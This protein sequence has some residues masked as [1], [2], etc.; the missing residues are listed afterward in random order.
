MNS[1]SVFPIS[2]FLLNATL[3]FGQ[4]RYDESRLQWRLDSDQMTYVI[5]VNQ[6]KMV[7][8]LYWGPRLSSG[9]EIPKAKMGAESSSFDP[10]MSTTQLEYPAW[11]AGLS[12]EPALKV[13]SSNGDR[14]LVLEYSSAN[15]NG[16]LLE[17]RLRD[18]VQPIAVHLFYRVFED[19]GIIARW[20]KIEN[21][22][23]K[24]IVVEQVASATWNL[25]SGSGY[26]WS[27]LTGRWAAEWQ[28]HTASIQTGAMVIES[29]RG[30]T[31]HQANPW[32]SVGRSG[33]TTEE[34]GPVWFGELG[35]SGS[36]R[37]VVEST[38]FDQVRITAGYNPFDFAYTSSPRESPWRLL[39][40]MRASPSTATV[41]HRARCT[42]SSSSPSC[43]NT[44]HQSR[45][46]SSTT[47]G[48]LQVSLSMRA[49]SSL[50]RRRPQSSVLSDS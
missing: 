49:I 4:I 22:G 16:D 11:G 47:H 17:L 6:Q 13:T 39:C 10:S 35:W 7:Q 36:W 26:E 12:T 44:P 48:R 33:E 19:Q 43:H 8:S 31:S 1:K 15:L 45:G 28:L 2:L 23:D 25:P 30:S 29:R 32:F 21:L 34:D 27:W 42:D 24:P 14:T 20:S 50:W 9:S 18:Q 41:A 38:P 37:M 3:T 5:G 46:P 40:F